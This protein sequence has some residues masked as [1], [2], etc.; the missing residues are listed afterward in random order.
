M[1]GGEPGAHGIQG[2][3]DGF[4]PD[5]VDMDFIDEVIAVSEADASAAALRIHRELGY[6]VGMSSGTNAVAASRL[7]DRGLKV[8]TVWPD[9]SDRYVSMG[10]EPPGAASG[11]CPLKSRCASRWESVIER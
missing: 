2:I 9:C 1:L 8:V 5:L 4:I 6:C 7:R 11:T 10:L 3:G